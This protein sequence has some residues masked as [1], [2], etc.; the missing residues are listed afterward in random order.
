M[1]NRWRALLL[2]LVILTANAAFGTEYDRF[3]GGINDGYDKSFVMN[4]PVDIPP[5]T[6]IRFAFMLRHQN[7]WV[8]GEAGRLPILCCKA[9]SI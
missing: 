1:K 5:G 2:A 6:I 3:K 4:T 9:I 7:L 8:T